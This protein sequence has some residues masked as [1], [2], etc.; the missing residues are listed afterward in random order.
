MK[1]HT[2]KQLFSEAIRITA[3]E[4]GIAEE[5]VEKDYWICLSYKIFLA[6]VMQTKWFGKV[7]LH[8]PRH[9][10]LSNDFRATWTLLSLQKDLAPTNKNAC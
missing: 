8:F 10:E 5:F 7:V 6:I 4:M 3:Y 1:L 9:T 2:D